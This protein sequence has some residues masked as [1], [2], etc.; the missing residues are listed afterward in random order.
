[1]GSPDVNIRIDGVVEGQGQIAQVG[2]PST[3][4]SSD[5]QYASVNLSYKFSGFT[6]LAFGALLLVVLVLSKIKDRRNERRREE[7]DQKLK[8]LKPEELSELS[9]KLRK[10]AE[11]HESRMKKIDR[12]M[13]IGAIFLVVIGL[14]AGLY[15]LLF[16]QETGPPFGF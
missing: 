1:M 11:R 12:F 10:D 8:G 2:S 6:F 14:I 16:A 13:N 9:D 3:S 5:E 15:L 7:F 4:K